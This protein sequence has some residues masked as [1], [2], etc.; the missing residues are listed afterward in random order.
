MAIISDYE[1]KEEIPKPKKPSSS[2][3]SAKPSQ[4]NANFD[5]SNPLGFLEKVFDFIAKESDFLFR[6]TVEKEIETV[7]RRAVEKRKKQE[8]SLE[9]GRK[10]EKRV[11][12]EPRTVKE[13]PRTVKEEPQTVA[14]LAEEKIDVKLEQGAEE[15]KEDNGP[16]GE[17]SFTPFPP[18]RPLLVCSWIGCIDFLRFERVRGRKTLNN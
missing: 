4:F 8:D 13:E 14:S 17:H 16:R 11:K 15:K 10:A 9:H 2:S 1:E 18:P 12:E 7:V 6:D 5:P 3:S